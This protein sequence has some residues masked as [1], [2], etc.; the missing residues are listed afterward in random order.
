MWFNNSNREKLWTA[1]EIVWYQ[2]WLYD[3]L[4][5][6]KRK[7]GLGT[8]EQ[9]EKKGLKLSGI[10]IMLDIFVIFEK[11]FYLMNEECTQPANRL[12]RS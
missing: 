6:E 8:K 1:R 10:Q 7:I 9:F 11:G 2:G 4:F 12:I 3:C 5:E